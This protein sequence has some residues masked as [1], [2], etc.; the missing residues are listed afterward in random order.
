M[1]KMKKSDVTE[2][3]QGELVRWAVIVGSGRIVIGRVVVEAQIAEVAPDK[4]ER[5]GYTVMEVNRDDSNQRVS[6]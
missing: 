2:S 4:V 6:F 1:M 5:K 3:P